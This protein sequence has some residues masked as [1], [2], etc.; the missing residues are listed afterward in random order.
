MT[1]AHEA[2]GHKTSVTHAPTPFVS[3]AVHAVHSSCTAPMAAERFAGLQLAQ[4]AVT[5]ND[6]EKALLARVTAQNPDDSYVELLRRFKARCRM[7]ARSAAVASACV[8]IVPAVSRIALA[9]S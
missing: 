9:S 6:A 1:M 4:I 2:V 5:G 8:A 7:G 3:A